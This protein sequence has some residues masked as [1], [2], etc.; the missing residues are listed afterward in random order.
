MSKDPVTN[1]EL[2]LRQ[3]I[4]A[5]NHC[6]ALPFE[7]RRKQLLRV[8]AI[9]PICLPWVSSGHWTSCM[10]GPCRSTWLSVQPRALPLSCR[11]LRANQTRVM[12]HREVRV[13]GNQ[14]QGLRHNGAIV[15]LQSVDFQAAVPHPASL[16]LPIPAP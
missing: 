7:E 4:P 16:L 5:R 9:C 13:A 3:Q 6:A 10:S 2:D 14:G 11:G 12:P 1:L 8:R 15:S